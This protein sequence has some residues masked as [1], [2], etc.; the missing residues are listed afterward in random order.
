MHYLSV[1]KIPLSAKSGG[2]LRLLERRA[3]NQADYWAQH[4]ADAGTLPSGPQHALFKHRFGGRVT[5]GFISGKLPYRARGVH[6]C[7]T[8]GA[9][10]VIDGTP[11]NRGSI[12]N[13]SQTDFR[14]L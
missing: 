12:F 10:A 8:F 3:K 11:G 14:R 9:K 7:C 4:M 1:L 2:V 6:N 13:C 5:I